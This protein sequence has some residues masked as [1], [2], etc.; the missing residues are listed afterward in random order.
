MS[1]VPKLCLSEAMTRRLLSIFLAVLFLCNAASLIA[2]RRM[3][4][5]FRSEEL[6]AK[7]PRAMFDLLAFKGS[8][9]EDS[10]KTFDSTRMDLYIAVPYASLEF[11]YAVDKYVAD[12]AVRITIRDGERILID[13]YESYNVLETLDEHK[14]R[15]S[16]GAFASSSS[17]PTMNA[18]SPAMKSA[19]RAD[20]EQ[21]S[22]QMLPGGEY[23][24]RKLEMSLN[25][26]DLSSRRDFDTTVTFILRSFPPNTTSVSDLLIYR[27]RKGMRIIPAIGSDVSE[28]AE[29]A[30]GTEMGGEIVET[31]AIQDG[32]INHDAGLFA[33]L[34][35][36]PADS[37]LGVVAEI[38]QKEQPTDEE[39]SKQS[40]VIE[41]SSST[42]RT[43]H[44]GSVGMTAPTMIPEMPLLIPLRFDELWQSHYTV[45]MYILPSVAD[46]TLTD[47]AA[48][49][50]RAMLKVDRNIQA[51]I[52][53]GIPQTAKDL[54]QAIEQLRFIADPTEEDSLLAART[55]K[56]KRSAIIAFWNRK[57]MSANGS[58]SS[59]QDVNRPMEVFYT[60]VAYANAHFG[61]SYQ[62]GWKTDR[63]RVYIALGQPDL[64]DS[65]PMEAMQKPYEIWQYTGLNARYTFVDEYMLGD[66]RL[67]G[68]FPSQGT[69]ILDR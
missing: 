69:F 65:H 17:S 22:F 55:P 32:S 27:D 44:A 42:F 63:G 29:S 66:Y 12:Y 43:V 2:Q 60:R 61:S 40:I 9:F 19:M 25:V 24:S 13:R 62:P 50:G 57:F 1:Y 67:R 52:A 11:L 4:S 46:T 38:M 28:W 35:D 30:G 54:D 15:V 58:Q 56:Q 7:V 41:K 53:R 47:P 48:L 21:I 16:H 20:A 37:T 49:D 3:P 23:P 34:Y 39:A 45:R 51:R 31:G 6:T 59:A 10:G 14:A 18:S 5:E 68:P 36:L 26:H 64:I 33:E 8:S